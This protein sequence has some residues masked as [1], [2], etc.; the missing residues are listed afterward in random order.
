MQDEWT[1]NAYFL[2]GELAQ[3]AGLV[4][5]GNWRMGDF[6]HVEMGARCRAARR[7]RAQGG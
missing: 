4:W 6:V 2:Y 7:A 5:G 3:A 1:R